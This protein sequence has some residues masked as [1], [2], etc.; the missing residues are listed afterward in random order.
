MGSNIR[1]APPVLRT[2]A[3]LAALV[4][5]LPWIAHH[6]VAGAV[7]YLLAGALGMGAAIRYPGPKRRLSARRKFLIVIGWPV[8]LAQAAFR[9][10][11]TVLEPLTVE[12]QSLRRERDQ[13]KREAEVLAA[14]V[15]ELEAARG[16]PKPTDGE[17]ASR[18]R[19]LRALIA[20]EFHPDHVKAEGMEKIIR[21]EIFKVLWPKVQEIDQA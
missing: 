3:F 13:W 2:A 16:D 19:R 11:A 4:L 10:L 5:V 18:F 17:D 21:A 15:H 7:V 6:G 8:F 14:R 20:T 9:E 1:T 12:Q